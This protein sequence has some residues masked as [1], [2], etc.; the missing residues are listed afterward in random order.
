MPNTYY[1]CCGMPAILSP[2]LS[3]GDVARI[4][5]VSKKQVLRLPIRRVSLGARLVRYDTTD[6]VTFIERQK[7]APRERP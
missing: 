7:L 5:G 4:L 6:V 2:L 3:A 1:L